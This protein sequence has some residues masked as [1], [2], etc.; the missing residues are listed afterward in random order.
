MT[1]Q[2]A[3]DGSSV[4][5]TLIA[6]ESKGTLY[7][8]RLTRF[9]LDGLPSGFGTTQVSLPSR[10]EYTE[11]LDLR[12]LADR[13][14]V[15]LIR[16]RDFYGN[17]DQT[18]F[19]RRYTANGEEVPDSAREYGLP[20]DC[21]P[22]VASRAQGSSELV[23]Y[24]KAARV[25]ATGGA[26]GLWDC[27]YEEIEDSENLRSTRGSGADPFGTY[28]TP[29]RRRRRP[30]GSRAMTVELQDV[31]YGLDLEFGPTG[32]PYALTGTY[33]K[34]VG[35]IAAYRGT[36]TVFHV[37]ADDLSIVNRSRDVPGLPVDLAVDSQARPVVW[38][39]AAD[40]PDRGSSATWHIWRLTA[41]SMSDFDTSWN[42]DGEA[43]VSDPRL[44]Y[45]YSPG[46]Q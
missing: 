6:T 39:E 25:T 5:A 35:R 34:S 42:G 3:A 11:L 23:G 29:E 15:V 44:D 8:L 21:V 40:V 27:A 2:D 26:F 19:L 20:A 28:V 14:F 22:P 36:S 37:K 17:G 30:R 7:D 1:D 31:D 38:T 32:D 24:I 16:G 10:T 18:L 41:P 33:T 43:V 46:R 12:V 9:G 4:T 13:S 45:A